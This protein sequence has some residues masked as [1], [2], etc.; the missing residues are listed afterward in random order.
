MR[1]LI[2]LTLAVALTPALA[3]LEPGDT[4]PD[5]TLADIRAEEKVTLSALR[6]QYVLLDFWA[7][8]CGPCR[9]AMERELSPLWQ[10]LGERTEDWTLI[11]IG[12]ATEGPDTQRAF[13]DERDYEWTFVHDPE[14]QAFDA[15]GVR[16]IPTLVLIN[17]KGV[18]EALDHH[19]VGLQ[20]AQMLDPSITTLDSPPPEENQSREN[21][22][23]SEA[24][25]R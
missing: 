22:K 2:A 11:S 21:T 18:V 23:P 14:R 19:G 25:T 10:R 3:A 4:A 16:G 12:S 15:Y 20:L 1:N 8:W 24:S 7:T 17:P 5:W 6:G 9:R 13:A